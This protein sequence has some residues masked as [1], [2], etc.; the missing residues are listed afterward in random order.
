MARS[1]Q[2]RQAKQKFQQALNFSV[3]QADLN[4]DAR[5]QLRNL[6][7]QQVKMGLVN[8]REAL[9]FRNNI[10]DDSAAGPVAG[11]QNG[12]FTPEY[13]RSVA[14]QLTD[15]D[16]RALETVADKIIEQQ[17]AAAGVVTAISV[18]MPEHGKILR[19]HRQLQ[20]DPAGELSVVFRARSGHL[21]STLSRLV[22]PLVLFLALWAGF[23]LRRGRRRLPA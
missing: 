11:F 19:F 20:I 16:N 6:T 8:R 2:Q 7:K 18:T 12:E 22:A 23:A 10:I 14:Q 21:L 3:G 17:A 4:E 1:G 5:V 15:K 13:A 9:R